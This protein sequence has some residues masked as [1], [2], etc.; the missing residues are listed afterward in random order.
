MVAPDIAELQVTSAQEAARNAE[1]TGASKSKSLVRQ[2]KLLLVKLLANLH[3]SAMSVQQRMRT[4][5]RQCCLSAACYYRSRQV[6]KTGA[7]S[8][9][10]AMIQENFLACAASEANFYIYSILSF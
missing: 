5:M 3:S 10:Y 7:T 6:L 2:V 4:W 1:V 8:Y 9:K